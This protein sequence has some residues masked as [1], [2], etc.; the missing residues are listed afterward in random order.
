MQGGM[1]VRCLVITLAITLALTPTLTLTLT[2]AFTLTLTLTPT[3]TLSLNT[4]PNPNPHPNPSPNPTP[5]PN[6]NPTPN[7]NQNAMLCEAATWCL[8]RPTSVLAAAP[9]VS[10]SFRTI[11]CPFSLAA[12][13]CRPTSAVTYLVRLAGQLALRRLAAPGRTRPASPAI[14]GQ[15]AAWVLLSGHG[16]AGAPAYPLKMIVKIFKLPSHTCR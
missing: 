6:P 8:T 12:A 1:L 9:I 11:D 15:P 5:N 13:I 2:L 10:A 14:L 4:I 16:D 7:P 3:L